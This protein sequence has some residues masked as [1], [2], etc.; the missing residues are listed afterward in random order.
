MSLSA[1]DALKAFG[2]RERFHTHKQRRHP[3]QDRVS[4]GWYHVALGNRAQTVLFFGGGLFASL[5]VALNADE[6]AAIRPIAMQS[7]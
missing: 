6:T 3:R 5:F 7:H 2:P 4:S 1:A